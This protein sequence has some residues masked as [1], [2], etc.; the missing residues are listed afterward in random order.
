MSDLRIAHET[1][2]DKMSVEIGEAEAF[3]FGIRTRKKKRSFSG[4]PA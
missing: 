1:R 2:S 4:Q 3:G